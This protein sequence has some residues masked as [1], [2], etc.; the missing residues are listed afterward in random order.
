MNSTPA[1]LFAFFLIPTLPAAA[2][3]CTATFT[4]ETEADHGNLPSG[5]TLNGSISYQ[6]VDPMRMGNETVSYLVS[7]TMRVEAADGSYV[8]GRLQAIHVTRTP[9][10]ADYASFDASDVTGNLGTVEAYEDPM[11]VTLF[12]PRG[13]LTTFDLPRDSAGWQAYSRRRVFQVHTP[14]TMWTLPGRISDF[15]MAC[16]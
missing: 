15:S 13:S 10:F 9:H 7:G 4:T 12:A 14:D 1:M 8:A 16:D 6:P 2:E 3:I 5:T 11:L